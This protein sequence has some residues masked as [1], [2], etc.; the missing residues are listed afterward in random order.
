MILLFN[1]K[2]TQQRLTNY[3][4]APWLPYYDRADIFIYSLHSLVP[5]K[6][7]ITKAVFFIE[8]GTEF[9]HRAEE[10]YA[11][12]EKLFPEADLY[13]F[14]NFYSSDWRANMDK[15]I[16]PGTD[17]G[18]PIFIGCNDD[19][20][21]MDYDIDVFESGLEL[22]R[23]SKDSFAALYYSHFSEQCRYSNYRQG[24]LTDDGNWV[25]YY[26]SNLDSIQVVTQSRF[27]EYWKVDQG[28]TPMF[29]TD[30]LQGSL[31]ASMTSDM[32][33]PTRR[34]FDH[35]DGYSHLNW[36]LP[37]HM[38]T[39]L[40]NI[41]PPL[42]IPPG[43]FE[44]RM[45]VRYGYDDH[46][47]DWININPASNDLYAADPNG[48]DYR[49]TLEDIPLFW[50]DRIIE[51][52]INPNADTELLLHSRDQNFIATTQIPMSCWNVLMD[53]NPTNLPPIKWYSR[54]LRHVKN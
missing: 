39:N 43:F 5:L 1:V 29:R 47:D 17:P 11:T 45:R 14:R 41:I 27:I 24:R 51:T 15:I 42:V 19:H 38:H 50:R 52:D 33:C 49:W 18:T 25:Q 4:R 30:C 28:S 21:F 44:G 9:A 32:Y 8:V 54:H 16:H 2:I 6:P 37:A 22:L 46:V 36:H 53:N 12:V 10:I 26:H 34:Q 7:L 3:Y 20:I 35:Y 40:N 48:V 31:S 23:Q 13:R